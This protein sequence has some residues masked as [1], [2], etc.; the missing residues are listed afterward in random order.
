MKAGVVCPVICGGNIDGNLLS[1]VIEQVLVRIN[2]DI[3]TTSEFEQRQVNAL[4]M[5]LWSCG[6]FLR[7]RVGGFKG[8]VN[9]GRRMRQRDTALFGR[10]GE[11]VD[12]AFQ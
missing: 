7:D 1:R 4:R 5:T 6:E 8:G 11:M 12:A 9:V 3:L 2:G 10:D